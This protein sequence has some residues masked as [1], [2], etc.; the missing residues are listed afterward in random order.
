MSDVAEE[1]H[2]GVDYHEFRTLGLNPKDV[3]DFS[4]NIMPFGP[5]TEVVQSLRDLAIDRYPDREGYELRST[6]AEHHDLDISQ[7]M[8]GNGCSELIH[9]AAQCWIKPRM[10]VLVLGPT[11][12]E[13]ARAT[14]IAGGLL[15]RVSV[16]DAECMAPT[17]TEILDQIK[18]HCPDLV[19]LCNPNNPTGHYIDTPALGD[20]IASM[21]QTKFLVDESYLE[22]VQDGVSL[23]CRCQPNL[24][25]LRSMTKYYAMAG[26]RLGYLS[27]AAQTMKQLKERRIPWSVNGYALAAGVAAIN[28]LAYYRDAMTKLRQAKNSLSQE[29][30][31][32]GLH[33]L[34]SS[35]PF[36]LLRVNNARLTRDHLLTKG[37]LVRDCES[38]GLEN[39]LRIS[40]QTESVN[41]RLMSALRT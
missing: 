16:F 7:I 12:S 23:F 40:T 26:L 15:H 25:V 21:P 8:L 37:I 10:R 19:W 29:L 24:I 38:F 31:G 41:A 6:L 17:A 22:F 28:S 1:I 4:S 20:L 18:L 3:I 35:V 34:P 36:F 11:F 2:G 39:T 9:L 13:Y 14:K 33:P 32:I 27:C 5:S 30:C